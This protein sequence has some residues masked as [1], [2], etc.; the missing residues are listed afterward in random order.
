MA[1]DLIKMNKY[2]RVPPEELIYLLPSEHHRLHNEKYRDRYTIECRKKMSDKAKNRHTPHN[3]EWNR[4]ISESHKGK[5]LSE[6]HKMALRKNHVGMLGKKMPGF[7]WY[8]NG[9]YDL[10]IRSEICPDGFV[11]GRCKIKPTTNKN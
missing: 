10:R 7:H 1:D 11:F 9:I 5:H 3:E 6:A 2:Y 8:N 4:R